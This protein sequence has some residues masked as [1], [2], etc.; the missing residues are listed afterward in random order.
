MSFKFH[1]SS[2]LFSLPAGAASVDWAVVNNS[3][4]TQDIQVTIFQAGNGPKTIIS[5][6]P[7]TMTIDP[8]TVVH[9]ANNVSPAG[10]FL[11]GMYY[12]VAIDSNDRRVLPMVNVWADHEGT[13]IPG[14]LISSRDFL[15]LVDP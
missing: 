12:E 14:T 2:G 9:N 10:P 6:G 11:P 3:P 4:G 5:P 8:G 13:A 7:L 15:H 1:L